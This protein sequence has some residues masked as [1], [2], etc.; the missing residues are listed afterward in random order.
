M[1]NPSSFREILTGRWITDLANTSAYIFEHLPGINWAGFYLLDSPTSRVFDP[2][3][4]E[5][6][7]LHLG[8]FQGRVACT[9]IGPGRGVCGYALRERTAV[10]VPDVHAFPAHIACDARSRSEVVI[11]LFVNDKCLGV[12]DVDSPELNRFGEK[13]VKWLQAVIKDLLDHPKIKS[14]Y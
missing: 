14:I 5:N 1:E 6:E 10:N 8:P 12:L 3:T 2:T 11:P 4:G 9:Y 7:V 13:E